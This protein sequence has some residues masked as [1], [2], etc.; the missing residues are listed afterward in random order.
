MQKQAVARAGVVAYLADRLQKRLRFNV[1][2]GAANLGDH[3]IRAAVLACRVDKRFDFSSDVWDHLHCLAQIF[4]A[5]FLLQHIPVDLAGRK[6]RKAVEVLVD[7]SFIVPEV[8]IGFNAVLG[9][10]HLTVLVG[11]HRA[12][13]DVDIRIKLLRD[14][15]VSARFEQTSERSGCNA[16]AKSRYD[17]A[18]YEDILC[19]FQLNRSPEQTRG[20]AARPPF[21]QISVFVGADDFPGNF[22]LC[23]TQIH[24]LLF[25]VAVR[26]RLG[27]AE[28]LDQQAFS[29]VDQPQI[30]QLAVQAGIFFQQGSQPVLCRRD[31][32]QCLVEQT[33][34]DRFFDY[35]NT[36]IANLLRCFGGHVGAC[37]KQYPRAS[38]LAD[39]PRKLATEFIGK[40]RVDNDQIVCAV[41]RQAACFAAVFCQRR[42]GGKVALQQRTEICCPLFGARYKQD[43][44]H[45]LTPFRF[46]SGR[47]IRRGQN[48]ASALSGGSFRCVPFVQ[49]HAASVR[50]SGAEAPLEDAAG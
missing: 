20:I 42:G 13:V 23:H 9:D 25:N 6:V 33:A 43:T 30:L 18:C 46:Q 27:H 14:N 37:D 2:G 39:A 12:G 45:Q 40:R 48:K 28:R 7:E 8:K 10:I 11:T 44:L 19:L 36:R 17:A 26:L 16:L 38:R 24:R 34:V 21:Y 49:L 41:E 15:P 32:T 1:A 22:T 29:P 35:E 50:S 4:A 31:K 3:N 47:G 5:A